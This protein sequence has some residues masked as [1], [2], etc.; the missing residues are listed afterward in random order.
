MTNSLKTI[1]RRLGLIEFARNVKR[2]VNIWRVAQFYWYHKFVFGITNTKFDISY[3]VFRESFLEDQ[4][5]IRKFLDELGQCKELLFLDIGRNHGLVFYYTMYYLMKRNI[6]IPVI[7]Y[8]GI[9]PSPLKF[10]YFNFHKEIAK[11]GM[12]INYNIVDRAV[13][14][15]GEPTVKLKYGEGNF[16]NFNVAGSNYGEKARSVQSYYEYVEINVETIKFSEL[17]TI[18]EHNRNADAII[19]KIDCKNRTDYMFMKFLDVLSAQNAK[20]LVSCETD[21]SSSRDVSSYKKSGVPVLTASRS[22]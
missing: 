20:F 12:R 8:Y 9:D 6:R 16:G 2:G 3:C 7:N 19:V 17:L 14:F 13:V 1:L 10:V 21:G 11:R 18:V 22:T 15:N 4:Y 5:N